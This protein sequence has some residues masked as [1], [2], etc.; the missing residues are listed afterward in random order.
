M[1]KVNK[2]KCEQLQ[3]SIRCYFDGIPEQ[4][5]DNICQAIVDYYKE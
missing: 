5:L 2:L 1:D 4:L 3:E